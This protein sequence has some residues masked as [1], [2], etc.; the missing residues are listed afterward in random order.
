MN[1]NQQKTKFN[2][3]NVMTR[4]VQKP[5]ILA[6]AGNRASVLAALAAGADAIY[7]GLKRFSARMEAMNFAVA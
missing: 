7:C 4:D 3:F 5:E 6:P 1:H 2:A